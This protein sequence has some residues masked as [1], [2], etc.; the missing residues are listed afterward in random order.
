MGHASRHWVWCWLGSL[1]LDC[2][3]GS[4]GLQTMQL[5][6]DHLPMV[7]ANKCCLVAGSRPHFTDSFTQTL[8]SASFSTTPKLSQ[9]QAERKMLLQRLDQLDAAIRELPH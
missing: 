9:L 4:K 1:S 3:Q 7:A 5:C 2:L 8:P 6:D